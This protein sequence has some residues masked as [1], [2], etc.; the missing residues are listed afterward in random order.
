[1][2][3]NDIS[4]RDLQRARG[5]VVQGK[6]LDATCP[7]GP[8]LVTADELPDPQ[9]LSITCDVNGGACRTATASWQ[10]FPVAEV[11]ASLSEGMTLLPGDV[12]LTGT[13][14]GIGSARTPP[15][16]LKDERRGRMP[17]RGIGA[18]RNVVRAGLKDA[19]AG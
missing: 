3:A 8:V 13:P 15:V 7:L 14:E 11:I 19:V 9:S 17:G 6:S 12:I 2:T 5:T 4:A 16:F 10:I 1:M 18:L